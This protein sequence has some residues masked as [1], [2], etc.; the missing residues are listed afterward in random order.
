MRKG[1]QIFVEGK[2]VCSDLCPEIS[3]EEIFGQRYLRP[4][5]FWR[6]IRKILVE[7]G[8]KCLWTAKGGPE[9]EWAG[10]W[11]WPWE[12]VYDWWPLLEYILCPYRGRI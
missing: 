8:K 2:N 3:G 5:Y 9:E 1:G 6:G 11:G 7:R 10:K 12:L 4:W